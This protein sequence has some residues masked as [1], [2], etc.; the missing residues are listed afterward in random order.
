MA[1]PMLQLASLC[2]LLLLAPQAAHAQQQQASIY[3]PDYTIY[4]RRCGGWRPQ[5]YAA[6]PAGAPSGRAAVSGPRRGMRAAAPG[7]CAS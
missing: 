2:A 3:A 7:L 4:K 6:L 1:A 5:T